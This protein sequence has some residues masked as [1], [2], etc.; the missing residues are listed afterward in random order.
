[1]VL[2]Y[3]KISPFLTLHYTSIEW[4]A[5]GH[6]NGLCICICFIYKVCM[7]LHTICCGAVQVCQ[8]V[9]YYH[10]FVQGIYMHPASITLGNNLYSS[11]IQIL[12][13]FN[14][15]IAFFFHSMCP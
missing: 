4:F 9:T 7:T 3:L 2:K 14:T 15:H 10:V 12:L 11:D 8:Y 13:S 6:F 5:Y 1:M